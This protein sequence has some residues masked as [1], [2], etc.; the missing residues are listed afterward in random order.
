MRALRCEKF[1]KLPTMQCF[2]IEG[3]GN[4]LVSSGIFYFSFF[5]ISF[6]RYERPSTDG[7][8]HGPTLPRVS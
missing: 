7:L 2:T 8:L 1:A 6:G 3:F 4:F 5:A